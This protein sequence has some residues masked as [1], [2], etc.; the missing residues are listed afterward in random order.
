MI[1]SSFFQY[2]SM[3]ILLFS[4]FQLYSNDISNIFIDIPIIIHFNSILYI[5]Q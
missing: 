2:F 3:I 4:I 5:F 1:L